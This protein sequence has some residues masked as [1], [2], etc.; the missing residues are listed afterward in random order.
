MTVDGLVGRTADEKVGGLV[1]MLVATSVVQRAD[2]LVDVSV[3]K[4]V[5]MMAEKMVVEMGNLKAVPWVE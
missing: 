3:E 1:A 5:V 2:K 4:L